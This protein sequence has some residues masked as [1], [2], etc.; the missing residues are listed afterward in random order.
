MALQNEPLLFAHIYAE[1]P[2]LG[3]TQCAI[4]AGYASRCRNGAH[5]R[6]Y[7]LLRDPRV[8]KAII[9]FSAKVLN[10]SMA[11]ARQNLARLAA[12]EKRYWNRWDKN[13]FNRLVTKLNSL[14][15]H[16]ERLEEIYTRV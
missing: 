11:E 3:A 1:D 2:R 15:I 16:R 12:T 9:F 4:Q 7:E 8:I 6:A 10:N 13:S 14:E 5:V